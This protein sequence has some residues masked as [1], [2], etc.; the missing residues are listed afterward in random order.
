MTRKSEESEV[1]KS[2]QNK[3]KLNKFDKEYRKFQSGNNSS[4]RGSKERIEWRW[5][6]QSLG[7][8]KRE[9]RWENTIKQSEVKSSTVK[10]ENC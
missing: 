4:V 5:G 9:V 1:E 10:L 6:N 2:S 7:V 3:G 8:K